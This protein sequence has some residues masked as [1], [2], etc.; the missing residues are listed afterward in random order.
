MMVMQTMIKLYF[1]ILLYFTTE[2]KQF[3][4][5][6]LFV[7]HSC[8]NVKPLTASAWPDILFFVGEFL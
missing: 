5:K 3:S 8:I 2:Y 7:D 6:Q 4:F 1:H